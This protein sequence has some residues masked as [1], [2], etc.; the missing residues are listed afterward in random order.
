MFE[1]LRLSLKKKTSSIHLFCSI[2]KE[3]TV[4]RPLFKDPFPSGI[5]KNLV[6]W[7]VPDI[8]REITKFRFNYLLTSLFIHLFNLTMNS[9]DTNLLV[10]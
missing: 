3:E 2:H 7:R 4:E 10:A 8:W 9:I 5:V 1:L 6:F